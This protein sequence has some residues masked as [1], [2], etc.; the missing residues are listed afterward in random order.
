GPFGGQVLVG[1]QGQSKISRVFM[2]K[3]NGEYQGAAWDFRSGFQSGV[4]RMTWAKDGS[5]FVGE[6]NRGWGSAGDANDGLQRLVWDNRGPFQMR[7]SEA[8]AACCA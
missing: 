2:E 4:L 1:D 6:T 7:T 5:L 8:I 3:V